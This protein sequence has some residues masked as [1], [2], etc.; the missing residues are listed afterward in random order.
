M[1]LLP[2]LAALALV[3]FGGAVADPTPAANEV[4]MMIHGAVEPRANIA[5][6]IMPGSAYPF[7]PPVPEAVLATNVDGRIH[8]QVIPYGLDARPLVLP[9]P[10]LVIT[11]P[12]GRAL[13]VAPNTDPA[14]RRECI[15]ETSI[16]TPA[17]DFSGP[18]AACLA[19]TLD[20]QTF[21]TMPVVHLALRFTT[22]S[23]LPNAGMPGLEV[24]NVAAH[25]LIHHQQQSG[26]TVLDKADA[27][28]TAS[29]GFVLQGLVN[30]SP[31]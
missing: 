21:R 23:G 27:A 8:L 28:L 16:V 4:V 29:T 11:S 6:F 18:L 30:T 3:T 26:E 2:V 7:P 12:E 22:P 17:G 19:F 9:N 14:T 10:S 20:P 1:K 5:P 13:T 25:A 31:T 15:E 24:Y